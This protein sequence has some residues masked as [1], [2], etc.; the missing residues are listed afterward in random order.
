MENTD[1]SIL[2][3]AAN[4]AASALVGP[5]FK[6]WKGNVSILANHPDGLNINSGVGV[7][8]YGLS[9]YATQWTQRLISASLMTVT[10][11]ES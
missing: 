6:N 9:S 3:D 5:L 1:R 10:L 8:Q 4:G 2:I 11:T 7:A